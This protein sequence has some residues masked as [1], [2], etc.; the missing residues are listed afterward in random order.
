MRLFDAYR[1]TTLV[2]RYTLD[3]VLEYLLDNRPLIMGGVAA[4]ASIGHVWVLDGY[5]QVIQQDVTRTTYYDFTEDVIID[6]TIL[7]HLLHVN[8]GWYGL[9][10][11]YYL[12]NVFNAGSRETFDGTYDNNVQPNNLSPQHFTQYLRMLKY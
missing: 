10:D 3:E 11:G 1:N 8:W 5:V 9:C 2:Y 7:K 12:S 6:E 4:N